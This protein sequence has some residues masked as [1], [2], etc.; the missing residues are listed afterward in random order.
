MRPD[1]YWY[2]GWWGFHMMMPVILVIA[3]LIILYIIFGRGGS[4]PTWGG[5][6][7]KRYPQGRDVES[8]MDILKKRYAGGEIGKQEYEQIKKDLES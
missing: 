6:S 2:G 8:A 5:D 7:D 1:Y 4:R 3:V